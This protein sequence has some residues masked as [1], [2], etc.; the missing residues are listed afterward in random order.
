MS[1]KTII[2]TR[3]SGQARQLIEVLTRSIE[4][5]GVAKRSFPEILS[6]PLLTIVPKTD[7]VLADHI[8]ST[9]K[10]ADLAIF[11][12]PNAIECVMRLLERD[13]QDFSKSIIPIGV[14][15]GSSKSALQNHGIGAEEN[16]TPIVMPQDN[17]QWDSEGLWHE[18]QSLGWNW[19]GKKVVIFKG[20]GGRDWLADTLKKAG[21]H[22][23]A[24]PTYTRVPLDVDNPA[25]QAVHDLDFSKSLWLLTSSEAVRYLGGVIQDQFAQSLSSASALCPHHNIADAAQEIGFGEVFTTEPGDEA[26]IKAS[27]AWLT[28]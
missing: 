22:V 1:A 2:V 16:P 10:N 6:L 7:E 24:I 3:P 8:A 4:L 28:L 14:M 21:A 9:L 12:S 15:G 26:L 13:W 27:L 25:W 11:V 17:E 19:Q 23:E 5:S 18:L 20:E